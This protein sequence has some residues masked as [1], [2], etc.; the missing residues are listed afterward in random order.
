[1]GPQ[2]PEPTSRVRSAGWRLADM[3]VG[4]VVGLILAGLSYGF[5]DALPLWCHAVAWL[6]GFG[7]TV[8][9]ARPLSSCM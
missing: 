4:C 7:G 9:I 5:L 1:M 2:L 3:G 8:L 6:M